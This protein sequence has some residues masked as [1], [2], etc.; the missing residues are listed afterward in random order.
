MEHVFPETYA[1]QPKAFRSSR[2]RTLLGLVVLFG[3]PLL[4]AL[5]IHT[6]YASLLAAALQEWL[7]ALT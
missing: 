4:A 3:L 7:Q 1:E 6:A 2:W 5:L